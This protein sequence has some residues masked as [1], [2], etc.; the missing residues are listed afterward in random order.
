MQTKESHKFLK[1]VAQKIICKFICSVLRIIA[2]PNDFAYTEAPSNPTLTHGDDMLKLIA[3]SLIASSASLLLSTA[4]RAE[5][6]ERSLTAGLFGRPQVQ[7]ISETSSEQPAAAPV[8][9]AEAPTHAKKSN[10]QQYRPYY[11]SEDSRGI[12]AFADYILWK[13]FVKYPAYWAMTT[14]SSD[15]D[16]NVGFT[17][18]KNDI[19]T[20][21][22]HFSSG[23]RVGAGYRFSKDMMDKYT[24]PWQIETEYTRLHTT[25]ARSVSI[26]ESDQDSL[27][28]LV[29]LFNVAFAPQSGHS[30]LALDYDRLDVKFAWPVWMRYNVIMRLMIGATFIWF[31]NT[32]QSHFKSPLINNF[33]NKSSNKLKWEYWGG[34]LFGGADINVSIGKGLGFY[35]DG[36]FGLTTG[37]VKEREHYHAINEFVGDATREFNRKLYT[38]QPVV[39]L[40]AGINYKHWFKDKVML[41]LSAGWDFTLWFHMNKFGRP[42][43]T[44]CVQCG[45]G[46][47]LATVV[48][49]IGEQFD[50]RPT[51]LGFQGF[52]G[53]LGLDF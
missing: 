10:S 52:V 11:Y 27:I 17:K 19:K 40:E 5:S 41:Y 33:R 1:R 24:R 48:P 44:Q 30:K 50:S 35:V 47:T 22:Y 13:P 21:R 42:S 31:E 12:Y 38:Y 16:P 8:A 9:A 20:L 46:P 53:R 34:G 4:L 37:K 36:S 32:W 14:H 7:V 2:C 39:D 26:P 6:D 45:G 3:T 49:D 15:F 28:P 25:T 23:F 43:S 18:S 51:D 29:P